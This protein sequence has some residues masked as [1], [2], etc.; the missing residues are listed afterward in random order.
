M[1]NKKEETVKEIF[2]SC[3]FTSLGLH[4]TLCD[5]LR[6]RLGFEAPT[7]VQAEAIPVILAGRHVLVNAATGTGKTVAYLA[8]II[9]H[10]Q[11]YTPRID[12]S[13]G[14]FGKE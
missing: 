14:T 3:S 10:L 13:Y 2:A 7:L 1:N 5:Q 8:P 9:H 6:E 11:S 4:S 12:R